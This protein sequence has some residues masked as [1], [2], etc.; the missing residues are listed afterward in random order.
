MSLSAVNRVH[1]FVKKSL[2]VH[3]NTKCWRALV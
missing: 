3:R 1:E 2:K